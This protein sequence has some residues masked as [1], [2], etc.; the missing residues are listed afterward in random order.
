MTIPAEITMNNKNKNPN[1][2]KTSSGRTRLFNAVILVLAFI[3]FL[4]PE[5]FLYNENISLNMI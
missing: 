3:L 5:I 2:L 4:F 1:C